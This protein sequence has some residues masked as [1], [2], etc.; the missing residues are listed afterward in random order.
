MPGAYELESGLGL[1]SVRK[2]IEEMGGTVGM[3]AEPGVG[4]R[5]AIVVPASKGSAAEQ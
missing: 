5:M 4:T 1:T 3:A 2:R